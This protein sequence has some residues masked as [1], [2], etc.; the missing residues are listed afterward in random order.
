MDKGQILSAILDIGVVPVVRTSSA[1]SAIRAIEAIYRG[2]IRSAE[3]TMTVPG[4]IKALEKIADQFGDK[5]VLGAGTV[6]DPETARACMLAGAE[7]FVTPN[8]RISTLEI[9]KRY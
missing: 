3:I 9:V 2:G 6:L 5:I 7:F 4:A 8:L 1:E